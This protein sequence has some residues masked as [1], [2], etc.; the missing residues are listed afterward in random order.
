M[1]IRKVFDL[2]FALMVFEVSQN[3]V[4]DQFWEQCLEYFEAKI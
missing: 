2:T 4:S 3:T 1:P